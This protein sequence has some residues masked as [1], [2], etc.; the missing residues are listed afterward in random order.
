MKEGEKIRLKS[1]WDEGEEARFV[2]EEVEALQHKQV[3]LQDMAILVRAGFQTRAFEDRFL[4]LGIPYRIIGGRRFY[5]REEIRDAVAYLRLVLTPSDD[6]AFERIVNVPRRGIGQAKMQQMHTYA[7]EN[8]K[9]LYMGMQDLLA[10]GE[11]KG[12]LGET[13]CKF[14]AQVARWRELMNSM[15]LAEV[16]EII[17]EESGYNAM[18]KAEKS[19]DAQ[20][21]LE[22]LKELTRAIGEFESLADFL[23][24]VSLVTEVTNAEADLDMISMMTLH[25]AKGLEFDVVFLPGWEEGVFP[26]QRA[27]DESGMKGLEEERRLAY[28]GITRARKKLYIR[29]A[30]SRRIFN[31]WQRNVPSRFIGELPAENVEKLSGGNYGSMGGSEWQSEIASI[32]AH[33][34]Q[35]SARKEEEYIPQAPAGKY[36]KGV[37][38]FNQKFGYGRIV[39]ANG[40]NL[41]VAFEKAGSKKVKAEYVELAEKV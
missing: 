33:H 1:L 38:V 17:L 30:S 25:A 2:G 29:H 21:R 10:S 8:G 11:L 36:A 3:S 22:N 14:S 19:P 20:G 7:R 23:E 15:P 35:R 13:I 37:R 39:S 12:K 32:M 24:H 9:S 40:N 5:D 26:H 31:Q 6:L 27:M 28:V 41:E 34:G 18:W 4:T 16:V